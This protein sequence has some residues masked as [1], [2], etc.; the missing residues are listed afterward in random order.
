MSP[1]P[2]CTGDVAQASL[3]ANYT[4]QSGHTNVGLTFNLELPL[5][6]FSHHARL[7]HHGSNLNTEVRVGHI[8]NITSLK[9]IN[10]SKF[11]L[12]FAENFP[13]EI[14]KSLK[15]TCILPLNWRHHHHNTRK[16]V[17]YPWKG[18]SDRC[19]ADKMQISSKSQTFKNDSSLLLGGRSCLQ[20]SYPK[21]HHIQYSHWLYLIVIGG[22]GLWLGM[23]M[24][25]SSPLHLLLAL[26]FCFLATV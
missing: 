19:N 23:R 5:R 9:E 21:G 2:P 15:L 7:G 3:F 14:L 22:A 1:L 12:H 13:S 24:F 20:S 8:S 6:Y 10:L 11:F 25:Q 16:S 17:K 4:V 18:H 26:V